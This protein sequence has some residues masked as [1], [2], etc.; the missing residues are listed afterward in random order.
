MVSR[1]E[2][3]FLDLKRKANGRFDLILKIKDETKHFDVDIID[4]D[5]IFGIDFPSE[6]H[7][8]LRESPILPKEIVNAVKPV[9]DELFSKRLQAA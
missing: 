5:G 8:L 6:L 4:R 3:K 1:N 9:Y 2:V 7:I